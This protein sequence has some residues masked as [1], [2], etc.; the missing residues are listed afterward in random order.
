MGGPSGGNARHPDENPGHGTT[1][2][3]IGQWKAGQKT[4]EKTKEKTMKAV[5]DEVAEN[6]EKEERARVGDQEM[7]GFILDCSAIGGRV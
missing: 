1:Q 6:A 4:K 5:E 2:E 3:I 7:P